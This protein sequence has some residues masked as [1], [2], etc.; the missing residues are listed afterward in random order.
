MLKVVSDF[1]IVAVAAAAVA[2]AAVAAAAVA[3]SAVVGSLCLLLLKFLLNY[4]CPTG[5]DGL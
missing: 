2:A 4:I 3:A 1:T 5:N